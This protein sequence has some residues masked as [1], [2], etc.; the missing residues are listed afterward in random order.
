MVVNFN[1]SSD[2]NNDEVFAFADVNLEILAESNAGCE[3]NLGPYGSYSCTKTWCPL[4]YNY[5]G[6]GSGNGLKCNTLKSC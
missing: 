1:V 6:C 5:G 2:A 3:I 4:T